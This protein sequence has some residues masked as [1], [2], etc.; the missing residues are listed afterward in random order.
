LTWVNFFDD[1]QVLAQACSVAIRALRK[2]GLHQRNAHRESHCTNRRSS[3]K[4]FAIQLGNFSSMHTMPRH[5]EMH[6]GCSAMRA[7]EEAS[8]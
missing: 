2:T 8:C 7:C 4:T 3:A 5:R 6:V 1:R